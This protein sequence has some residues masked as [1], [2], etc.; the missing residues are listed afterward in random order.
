MKNIVIIVT[1]L[2]NFKAYKLEKTN[3]NTPRLELMQESLPVNGHHAKIVDKVSD[4]A[5]RYHNG[6][7]GK[8]ATP[9][10]EPHNIELEDRKRR[11]RHVAHE[12]DSILR[13]D[14]IDGCWLAAS[15][16][17]NH[18]LLAE[19]GPQARTKILKNIPAD[20]TRTDKSQLLNHFA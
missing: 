1:D 20:L 7:Q 3:L 11:V 16:E 12:L 13:N 19:L 10:G 18:Q 4:Q 17:I 5:G 8:W 2:G 14:N 15:K 9:W 6:M